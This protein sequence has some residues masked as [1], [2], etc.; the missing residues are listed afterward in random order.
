[1]KCEH[2]PCRIS[3]R[4]DRPRAADVVVTAEGV[5][6]CSLTV[7][8]CSVFLKRLALSRV[9]FDQVLC[10]RPKVAASG[11]AHLPPLLPLYRRPAVHEAVVFCGRRDDRPHQPPSEMANSPG[12]LA[13]AD[14]AHASFT[15]SCGF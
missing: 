4:A 10:R 6:E 14:D 8:A 2:E 9:R 3:K 1:M 11:C 12:R 15:A 5:R 13:F 7:A